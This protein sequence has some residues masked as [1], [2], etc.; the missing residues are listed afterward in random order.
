M[1]IKRER[2]IKT[3]KQT[4]NNNNKN[5]NNNNNNNIKHTQTLALTGAINCSMIFPTRILQKPFCVCSK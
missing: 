2:Y 5:N 4:N 3:N 1:H